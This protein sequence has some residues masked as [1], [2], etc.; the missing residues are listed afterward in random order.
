MIVRHLHLTKY[1]SLHTKSHLVKCTQFQCS[2]LILQNNTVYV[3]WNFNSLS[4]QKKTAH[5]RTISACLQY[6]CSLFDVL[7]IYPQVPTV[8]LRVHCCRQNLSRTKYKT[9]ILPSRRQSIIWLSSHDSQ[10]LNIILK[11]PASI[12]HNP[13]I[14]GGCIHSPCKCHIHTCFVPCFFG[15]S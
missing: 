15:G 8:I 7:Q 5:L 14:V 12:R 6:M 13:S 3:K 11:Q 2:D 9:E 10:G 4:H 1:Y